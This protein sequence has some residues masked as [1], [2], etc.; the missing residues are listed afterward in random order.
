MMQ[1]MIEVALRFTAMALLIAVGLVIWIG[2]ARDSWNDPI[3][4]HV[5]KKRWIGIGLMAVGLA[6]HQL[7]WWLWKLAV[8]AEAPAVKHMLESNSFAIILPA[9]S[10]FIVGLAMMLAGFTQ[11]RFGAHWVQASGG[12]I[13]ALL[14]IGLFTAWTVRM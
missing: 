14:L 9:Y 10:L 7:W 12:I 6:P 8:V 5:R 2:L 3:P 4:P 11:P 1:S 13:S